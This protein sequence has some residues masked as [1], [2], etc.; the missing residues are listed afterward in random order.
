MAVDF[1][2]RLLAQADPGPGEKVVV[3]PIN[4]QM[5]RAERARRLGHDT[6]AHY[7]RSIHSYVGQ[8]R[9]A[10]ALDESISIESLRQRI[11]AAK[12]GLQ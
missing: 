7:R 2:G 11:R 4:I 9:L 3:A 12:E 10:P 6:R 8:E 5:L 1:D